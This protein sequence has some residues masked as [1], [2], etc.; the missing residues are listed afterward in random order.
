MPASQGGFLGVASPQQ[1]PLSEQQREGIQQLRELAAALSARELQLSLSRAFLLNKEKVLAESLF[2]S[3]IGSL[4]APSLL[5]QERQRLLQLVGWEGRH[6]QHHQEH[7][8]DVACPFSEELQHQEAAPQLSELLFRPHPTRGPSHIQMLLLHPR[9]SAAA[10]AFAAAAAEAGGKLEPLL[11]PQAGSGPARV[12]AKAPSA[13]ACAAAAEGMLNPEHHSASTS[14]D[15]GRNTCRSVVLCS[16]GRRSKEYQ[17]Q[18]EISAYDAFCS[19]WRLTADPLAAHCRSPR[20]LQ[21][22]AGERL[23]ENS[24]ITEA[25]PPLVAS[26]LWLPSEAFVAPM[27][28]QEA[29]AAIRQA[30]ECAFLSK[31]A[32]TDANEELLIDDDAHHYPKG[33]SYAPETN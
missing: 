1:W 33:P 12:A 14:K 26:G 24:C 8:A 18:E 4:A 29:I 31:P 17:Q 7:E 3:N 6:S 16:R 13:T 5:L 23:E 30:T 11:P 19:L 27:Q 32:P 9:E 28:Q 10:A 2:F 20:V 15:S 25:L 22:E 21:D